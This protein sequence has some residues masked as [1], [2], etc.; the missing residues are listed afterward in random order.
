MKQFDKL[1]PHLHSNKD[2]VQIIWTAKVV[3]SFLQM[4]YIILNLS[5]Y[6][7]LCFKSLMQFSIAQN[8]TFLSSATDTS[9]AFEEFIIQV[10]IIAKFELHKMQFNI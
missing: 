3:G 5:K 6:D 10:A 1:K 2:N 8:D 9:D 7:L 4:N